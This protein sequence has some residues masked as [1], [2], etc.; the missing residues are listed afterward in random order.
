MCD[1]TT[2]SLPIREGVE[3][4]EGSS[5]STS[6]SAV[7]RPF[8]CSGRGVQPFPVSTKNTNRPCSQM[9]TGPF[10]LVNFNFTQN[11]GLNRAVNL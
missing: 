11:Q 2:S 3:S 1:V 9:E 5:D 6:D 4:R 8:R 7:I 10:T